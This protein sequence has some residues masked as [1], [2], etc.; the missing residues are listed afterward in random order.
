MTTMTVALFLAIHRYGFNRHIWN[1][2]TETLINARKVALVI[3]TQYMFSTC[4]TKIS[5]LL[6]YRRLAAGT[7][8]KVFQY[9]IYAAITFVI[10]YFLVF[11]VVMF[12][13]CRPFFAYWK[14]ADHVWLAQNENNFTC[15]DEGM[16]IV[17]SAVISALQDFIACGLPTILFWKLRIP[18]RQKIA[19]GGI[20]AL[21]FFLC[22]CA[23]LRIYYIYRVFYLSYDMTWV[24]QPA[25][26]WVTVEAQVAVICASAPALKVFF[27]HALSGSKTGSQRYGSRRSSYVRHGKDNDSGNSGPSA[28]EKGAHEYRGHIGKLGTWDV[29]VDSEFSTHSEHGEHELVGLDTKVQGATALPK[30]YR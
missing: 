29:S 25:W 22:V 11:F 15:I 12:F 19:L 27:K 5:I 18:R 1:V 10:L 16:L 6:F 21:G 7:V 2:P 20:F 26:L 4:L 30:Y 13:T 28:M 8:S 3:E 9:S 24:S 14:Q 23:C 17:S